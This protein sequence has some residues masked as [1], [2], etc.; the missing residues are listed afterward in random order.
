MKLF[1]ILFLFLLAGLLLSLCASAEELPFEYV[2]LSETEIEITR[3]KL[4]YGEIEI[5]PEIGGHTV[6]SIAGGAFENC[7]G[8]TGEIVI[9]ESITSIGDSAFAG[10]WN[11]NS[12]VLPEKIEKLGSMAFLNCYKLKSIDLGGLK[13]IPYMAFA[14][15]RSLDSITLPENCVSAS[16][17]AFENCSNLKAI[18]V[19]GETRFSGVLNRYTRPAVYCYAGSP[20]ESWAK[21][22]ELEIVLLDGKNEEDYLS[23]ALPADFKINLNERRTL[24][25]NVFPVSLRS[26]LQYESSAPEIISVDESGRLT[27][28][29]TG[30]AVITASVG[31]V[32]ES[33]RVTSVVPVEDFTIV[34]ESPFGLLGEEIRFTIKT[35]PENAGG[36]ILWHSTDNSVLRMGLDS[37][38]AEAYGPGTARVSALVN[39]VEKRMGFSV[40]TPGELLVLPEALTLIDREAFAG[41]TVKEILLGGSVTHIEERAFADNPSLEHIYMP[42]S[43]AYIAPDAFEGSENVRLICQSDNFAAAFARA[44]AIDF[45]IEGE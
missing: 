10:C 1:R 21:S 45:I 35:V 31:G 24:A 22:E 7:H 29:Q 15:C 3:C 4:T 23:L 5:P 30:S 16:G 20:A 40:Y 11:L 41:T 42:D 17:L 37:G 19:P 44:N 25:V 6:T 9:P 12:I 27:A 43:L 26:D 36:D 2:T 39:G 33:V 14:Y 34:P 28:H 8:L 13:E 38:V 32:S 18:L